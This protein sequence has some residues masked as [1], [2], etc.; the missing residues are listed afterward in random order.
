MRNVVAVA[1]V[2]VYLA[3]W[4]FDSFD[5]WYCTRMRDYDKEYYANVHGK[6]VPISS[7]FGKNS[8]V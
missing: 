1:I 5:N 2:I 6:V 3:L 8:E 7:I 4:H